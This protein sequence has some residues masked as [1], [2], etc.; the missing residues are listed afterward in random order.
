MS[1]IARGTPA[2]GQERS[3]ELARGGQ[4][5]VA[6]VA[7]GRVGADRLEQRQ[8]AAQAVEHADRGVGVG[9]ADVDVQRADRRRAGVAEQL[10]DALVAALL[11][12]LRVALDG[13]RVRAAGDDRPRPWR[14]PRGAARTA[15]RRPRARVVQ[16]P[17]MSSIWLRC[18][19]FLISPRGSS[20]SCSSTSAPVLTRCPSAGST[21]NSSSSR[22]IV[23]G[24]PSPKCCSSSCSCHAAAGVPAAARDQPSPAANCTIDESI[25]HSTGATS[26]V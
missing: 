11:G 8:V 10:V 19:S 7:V 15:R 17:V 5:G 20:P 25:S 2:R 3:V 23:N 12:E 6:A 21:R 16:T 26:S 1:A 18:S 14:A 24:S 4:A 9:H 22:P 13:R